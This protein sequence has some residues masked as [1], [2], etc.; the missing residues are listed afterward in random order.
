MESAHPTPQ[1]QKYSA[2]PMIPMVQSI[3][4]NSLFFDNAI[5]YSI[6]QNIIFNWLFLNS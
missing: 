1:I 2:S 3:E 5:S 4:A 6:I